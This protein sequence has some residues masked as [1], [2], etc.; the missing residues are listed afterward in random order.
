[1]SSNCTDISSACMSPTAPEFNP[2]A[3][4][5]S[6]YTQKSR[7]SRRST[8]TT[9]D[10][11]SSSSSSTPSSS[12][13]S[14]QHP[15]CRDNPTARFDAVMSGVDGVFPE[16]STFLPHLIGEYVQPTWQGICVC[17]RSPVS[18][19]PEVCAFPMIPVPV[20]WLSSNHK[21]S[22]FLCKTFNG[23]W[24]LVDVS[25]IHDASVVPKAIPKQLRDLVGAVN[26]FPTRGSSTILFDDT[27]NDAYLVEMDWC[28]DKVFAYRFGPKASALVLVNQIS[29][30]PPGAINAYGISRGKMILSVGLDIHTIRMD[31]EHERSVISTAFSTPSS[32]VKCPIST[33][34]VVPTIGLDDQVLYLCEG[35]LWMALSDGSE[36]NRIHHDERVRYVSV[37]SDTRT[38]TLL[39][40]GYDNHSPRTQYV[41]L[42]DTL[43]RFVVSKTEVRDAPPLSIVSV[44][45]DPITSNAII[46]GR[47]TATA[48]H[49]A[50]SQS[51]TP[52]YN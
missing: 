46:V 14:C 42:F 22:Y 2:G 37:C 8:P 26:A 6:I 9:V 31:A 33:Q 12:R 39:L 41:T 45:I 52:L 19:L 10:K 15:D 36:R 17:N 32:A 1:M 5:H 44:G 7:V 35:A 50:V 30:L 13:S 51:F 3:K 48:R 28:N 40:V 34:V 38:N 29:S 27:T 11:I 47:C 25:L 16:V 24:T 21:A 20:C 18:I 49:G 43:S 23:Q 4:Y